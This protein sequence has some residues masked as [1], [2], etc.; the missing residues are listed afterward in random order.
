MAETGKIGPRERRLCTPQPKQTCIIRVSFAGESD[1]DIAKQEGIKRDTVA[2]ILSQADVTDF[3]EKYRPQA[4]DPGATLHLGLKDKL[5]THGGR[6]RKNVDWHMAITMRKGE[7]VLLP[8]EVKQQE[9]SIDQF[10]DWP[11]EGPERYITTG[12]RSAMLPSA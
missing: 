7:Q 11:D 12:E 5:I 2:E 9:V 6:L 8:C 10:R 4:L 1:R 3:I